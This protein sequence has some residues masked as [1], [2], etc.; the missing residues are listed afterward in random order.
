MPRNTARADTYAHAM[1]ILD[2]HP[3]SVS[4]W[5]IFKQKEQEIRA[6]CG[7][8]SILLSEIEWISDKLKDVRDRTHFHIDPRDIFDP[9]AV[10]KRAGIKNSRFTAVLESLWK[11]LDHCY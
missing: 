10:W 5:Y 11:I 7:S 1:K 6:F 9:A 4:F 2:R 8:Q 3:Q